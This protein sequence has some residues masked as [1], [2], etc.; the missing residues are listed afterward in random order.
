MTTSTTNGLI[1]RR[2]ARNPTRVSCR[3][4]LGG[5][6]T[7]IMMGDGLGG[8]CAARQPTDFV[9]FRAGAA[10]LHFEEPVA[11]LREYAWGP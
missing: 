9:R 4:L 8:T 7:A 11:K 1:L 3:P 2:P 10:P 5:P 6:A